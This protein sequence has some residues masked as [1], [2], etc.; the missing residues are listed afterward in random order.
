MKKPP[1]TE[2]EVRRRHKIPVKF[3]QISVKFTS[4]NLVILKKLLVT[5]LV[6]KFR[7]FFGIQKFSTVFTGTRKGSMYWELNETYKHTQRNAEILNVNE[8]GKHSYHYE[9]NYFLTATRKKVLWIMHCIRKELFY[10]Y[11]NQGWLLL[12]CD[13]ELAV[14]PA[15]RS[16]LRFDSVFLTHWEMR[17]SSNLRC[18][19]P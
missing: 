13:P 2:P 18:P 4:Y 12:V 14:F 8:G 5:Q 6:E 19:Y 17:R 11:I 9:S 3:S 15:Y 7:A 10:L 1:V 16:I